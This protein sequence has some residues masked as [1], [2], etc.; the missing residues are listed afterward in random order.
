MKS[1]FGSWLAVLLVLA[2]SEVIGDDSA[3]K[4]KRGDAPNIL[5]LFGT[6]PPPRSGLLSPMFGTG[7]TW[8][9]TKPEGTPV[10]HASM[11]IQVDADSDRSSYPPQATAIMTSSAFMEGVLK[12]T[13]SDKSEKARAAVQL[14]SFDTNRVTRIDM[15]LYRVDG[16]DWKDG[17]GQRLLVAV[18]EELQ[19]A[20]DESANAINS[21]GEK[22]RKEWLA[23][24]ASTKDSLEK[25]RVEQKQVRE[26][27]QAIPLN[28]RH[29]GLRMVEQFLGSAEGQVQQLR[30]QLINMGPP[31]ELDPLAQDWQQVV[32]SR[33]ERLATLKSEKAP[34]N[35]VKEAE[36]ALKEAMA[37]AAIL[38][39]SD[40][41]GQFPF[42]VNEYRKIKSR[43]EFKEKE[44]TQYRELLNKL[45]TPEYE[46]LPERQQRLDSDEQIL[47]TQLTQLY[48]D[49]SNL[50]SKS[51]GAVKYEITILDGIP[52][53]VE[54]VA[55]P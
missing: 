37:I 41:P 52:D 54:P 13:L 29:D 34:E 12:K 16:V 49:R 2:A 10:Q 35:D 46:A 38:K 23:S 40:V 7:V 39:R 43:L 4:T 30:E 42:G 6:S 32:Q 48:S 44:V 36:L 17:D 53:I 31:P 21:A 15:L 47:R 26:L 9:S 27:W 28:F 33:M 22:A 20:F 3:L 19:R 45:N 11:V 1:S 8:P 5:R 18:K 51:R 25:V 50:A 55:S 24:V 14:I